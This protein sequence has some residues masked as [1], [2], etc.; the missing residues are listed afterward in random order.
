MLVIHSY[1]GVPGCQAVRGL[2]K[3]TRVSEGKE[4]GG[5]VHCIFLAALL[6]SK[7]DTLV[8]AL[9]EGGLAPW[10]DLDVSL[11]PSFGFGILEGT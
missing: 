2:D 4:E 1:G 5:I 11:F 10:Y 3:E 6:V 8:G 9:G 7:G